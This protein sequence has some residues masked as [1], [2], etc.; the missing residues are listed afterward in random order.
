LSKE[1]TDIGD[2]W[3]DF[4]SMAAKICKGRSADEDGYNTTANLLLDI[5]DREEQ[6]FTKLKKLIKNA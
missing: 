2:M 6:L 4:S 1:M 3:R 5:A